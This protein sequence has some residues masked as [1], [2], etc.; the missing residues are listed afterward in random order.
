M[1]APFMVQNIPGHCF[2]CASDS[3]STVYTKGRPELFLIVI[4]G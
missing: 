2:L 3:E 4:N 1:N